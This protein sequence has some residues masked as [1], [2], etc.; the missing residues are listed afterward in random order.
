MCSRKRENAWKGHNGL[1]EYIVDRT[2]KNETSHREQDQRRTMERR[3]NEK[4]YISLQ[5]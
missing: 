4:N 1:S 5:I 3:E 2:K